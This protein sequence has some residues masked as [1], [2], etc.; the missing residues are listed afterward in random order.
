[1]LARTVDRY[2]ER[3]SEASSLI[4]N[5]RHRLT[6]LPCQFSL[7]VTLYYYTTAAPSAQRCTT[8]KPGAGAEGR[9]WG[10]SLRP[11]DNADGGPVTI[12]GV[13]EGRDVD[14]VGGQRLASGTDHATADSVTYD[15]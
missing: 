10:C 14:G 5:P 2:V 1:V 15:G 6:E 7:K 3:P 11:C 8:R 12:I 13:E 4:I 9:R